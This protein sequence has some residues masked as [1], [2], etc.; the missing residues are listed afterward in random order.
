MA[1]WARVYVFLIQNNVGSDQM[2][3]QSHSY[4][5][6]EHFHLPLSVAG[7]CTAIYCVILANHSQ[8]AL[9]QIDFSL[10]QTGPIYRMSKKN[11]IIAEINNNAVLRICGFVIIDA[12]PK[13]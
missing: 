13:L 10:Q 6:T 1:Y 12:A 3:A 11:A 5:M 2:L 7:S 4:Q 9:L 8:S